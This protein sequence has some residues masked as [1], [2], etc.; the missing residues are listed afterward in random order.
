M[1]TAPMRVTAGFTQ[2]MKF[3]PLG[4]LG[5][6]DPTFYGQFY[7]EFIGYTPGKYT[8][9]NTGN[10]SIAQTAGAYG[11]LL[12][13]TNS[14]TPLVTDISS[15]QVDAAA[16]AYTSGKYLAFLTRLQLSSATNDTLLCG[17]I[18]TTTT[19]FTVVDGIY[20]SKATGGTA[21]TLTVMKGSASQGSVTIPTAALVPADATDFDLGFVVNASGEIEIYAGVNL[22]GQKP[23]QD[24]ALLGPMA[25]LTPTAFPTATLNPTLALQS[26]TATSKTMNVDLLFAAAER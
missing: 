23:N 22:L 1:S 7:D 15:L 4:R 24:V 16:F 5:I 10:G 13:T 8:L 9:T 20:F 2:A 21:I 14:S 6:P 3:Q 17:L 12:F 18:Q 26:G 11:R 25:R 19:P